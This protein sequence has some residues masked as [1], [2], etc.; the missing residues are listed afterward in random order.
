MWPALERST[1]TRL[2]TSAD[3][4][5]PHKLA[6]GQRSSTQ[7]ALLDGAEPYRVSR[8]RFGLGQAAK[9]GASSW[10]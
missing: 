6:T 2:P 1:P 3:R 4:L 9:A 10:A 7:G 8:R 5:L